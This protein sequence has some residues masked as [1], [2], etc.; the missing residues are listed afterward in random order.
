M[1]GPAL[2]SS[3]KYA[4]FQDVVGKKASRE[5]PLVAATFMT[6][7]VFGKA[8]DD[9]KL[10]T[11][12]FS[13]TSNHRQFF[14]VWSD[15]ENT[16][17][18]A[19]TNGVAMRTLK[20]Q[21]SSVFG[22]QVPNN[23]KGYD[24]GD[25]VPL[26]PPWMKPNLYY[27]ILNVRVSYPFREMGVFDSGNDPL[28]R[29]ITA[30]QTLGDTSKVY[31]WISFGWTEFD[32][33][34]YARQY[35]KTVMAQ[36][37]M[38]ETYE[39]STAPK[40]PRSNTAI[41][42]SSRAEKRSQSHRLI[43]VM[44]VALFC[45]D[46]KLLVGT[47]DTM[48]GTLKVFGSQTNP[49]Q[50]DEA[51]PSELGYMV[52][53]VIAPNYGDYK[54]EEY[55]K[56]LLSTY[57]KDVI[58]GREAMPGATTFPFILL[59]SPEL[60]IFVHLPLWSTPDRLVS[61]R[62]I[63]SPTPFVE[64]PPMPTD[65]LQPILVGE[66][67]E[68]SEAEPVYIGLEEL[69]VH[70]LFLGQ[71]GSGKTTLVVNLLL[72]LAKTMEEGKLKAC[73]WVI[74]PVGRLGDLWITRASEE[75]KKNTIFFEPDRAPWGMN[76]FCLPPM[77]TLR[78][79][80]LMAKEKTSTVTR[81]IKE[82]A[83]LDT[84][85]SQW[86]HR[87]R[88]IIRLI[89]MSFYNRG[90]ANPERRNFTFMD[91]VKLAY[92]VGDEQTLAT[93]VDQ[94]GLESDLIPALGGY[95]KEAR[96]A[97]LHKIE[98][99]VEPV[100][101]DFICADDSINF[102]ELD[103][104]GNIIFFS[105]KGFMHIPDDV[106]TLMGSV[107][108]S[109]YSAELARKH[110]LSWENAYQTYLVI[111]EFHRTAD[112]L[113]FRDILATARNIRLSM[114][115]VY[116]GAKQVEDETLHEEVFNNAH[117]KF[118][119][120]VGGNLASALKNDLDIALGKQMAQR[121]QSLESFRFYLLRSGGS[122]LATP[123]PH[124]VKAMPFPT[125]ARPLEEAYKYFEEKMAKYKPPMIDSSMGLTGQSI[126]GQTEAELA[127]LPFRQANVSFPTPQ[128]FPVL[129]GI[130]DFHM[131][132]EVTWPT[133]NQIID[134]V[135]GQPWAAGK[136]RSREFIIK[137]VER[138]K[139]G[140]VYIDSRQSQYVIT[141]RSDEGS[142]LRR[143]VVLLESPQA[144]GPSGSEYHL[145]ITHRYLERYVRERMPAFMAFMPPHADNVP[146][147]VIVEKKNDTQWETTKLI[148][149][150]THMSHHP[151]R[152][153]E[154]T[155]K[156][157]KQGYIK[158]IVV[159]IRHDDERDIRDAMMKNVEL[160]AKMD[161]GMI[162]LVTTAPLSSKEEAEEVAK[163][164]E[165]PEKAPAPM[166]LQTPKESVAA[167]PL[168]SVQ[169]EIHDL[170]RDA[171]RLFKKLEAHNVSIVKSTADGTL[172]EVVGQDGEK[173]LV[174]VEARYHNNPIR[175]LEVEDFVKKVNDDK[176]RGTVGGVYITNATFAP[177]CASTKTVEL[178][179]GNRLRELLRP[180]KNP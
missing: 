133:L 179:D 47:L 20:A 145:K 92:A 147:G 158:V 41:E 146:D 176:R 113:S 141:N 37:T 171:L 151:L 180:P 28:A 152:A 99:F 73:I 142:A 52:R 17:L 174:R 27:A 22:A 93:V 56:K 13:I 100:I 132:D 7:A 49:V 165:A 57:M 9:K 86:G 135:V 62:W 44:R 88:R 1:Q 120:T 130:R 31:S 122:A 101:R 91:V 36:E 102:F 119:F 157:F 58:R 115:L 139:A 69:N 121:L 106:A 112:L 43:S 21:I 61:L 75:A 153:L 16:E 64:K 85:Q 33:G 160:K 4:Q 6:P 163:P 38:S 70:A 172:Y 125:E 140:Y 90:M 60:P 2:L 129:W 68:L 108:M 177:G 117:T 29:V 45:E 148:A 67:M 144:G 51:S 168:A 82:V 39:D 166:Q 15:G 30:A 35:T 87:L 14:E 118:I 134:F 19:V 169:E 3:E 128:D 63:K 105:F 97:V 48:K 136:M 18:V 23:V 42:M 114:W 173:M 25:R 12:A 159:C 83:R 89:I 50:V 55:L 84:G 110:K 53:R 170:E 46:P 178:V 149:V 32:W 76:P 154:Q 107:I 164:A 59:T 156:R 78:E 24:T 72:Q 161:G 65:T 111:D 116:Q 34:P 11:F 71:S 103:Q 10:G 138:L 79:Y 98:R 123:T 80:Q 54:S 143:S 162:E 95:N 137:T 127:V 109:I 26:L 40:G 5:N 74:D 175:P 8:M 150:E 126:Q 77:D 124:L 167:L 96:D 94:M 131:I 155:L 81:M 104:P 66:S